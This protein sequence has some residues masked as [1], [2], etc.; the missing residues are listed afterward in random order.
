MVEFLLAL[1]ALAIAS[2]WLAMAAAALGIPS[3]AVAVLGA[4]V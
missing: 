3:V 2:R 1:A 4:L